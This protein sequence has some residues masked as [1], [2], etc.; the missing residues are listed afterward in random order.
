MEAGLWFGLFTAPVWVACGF[1]ADRLLRPPLVLP[2]GSVVR[3]PLVLPGRLVGH[4]SITTCC[5]L[6]QSFHPMWTVVLSYSTLV[7]RKVFPGLTWLCLSAWEPID[8]QL[9]QLTFLLPFWIYSPCL[10]KLQKSKRLFLVIGI[11][12]TILKVHF[13]L[14]LSPTHKPYLIALRQSTYFAL[15]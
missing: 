15:N 8:R 3:T 7:L 10:T 13:T 5:S 4:S 1:Q 12:M 6:F 2:D 14:L 11:W 9:D